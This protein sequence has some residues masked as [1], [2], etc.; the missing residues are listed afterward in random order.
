MFELFSFA[1]IPALRLPHGSRAS[2]VR[3]QSRGQ[4]ADTADGNLEV[5]EDCPKTGVEY[6]ESECRAHGGSEHTRDH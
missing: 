5:L 2:V 3:D 6:G 1:C 4:R